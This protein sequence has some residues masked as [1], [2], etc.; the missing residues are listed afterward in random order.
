MGR[1]PAPAGVSARGTQRK[2]VMPAQP[3]AEPGGGIAETFADIA[4]PGGSAAA[5]VSRRKF[6]FAPFRAPAKFAQDIGCDFR[7]QQLLPAPAGLVRET[8]PDEMEDFVD[9][10][11]LKFAATDQKFRIKQ[12]AAARNIRRGEMGPE[13]DANFDADRP[14]GKM[15]Q[16]RDYLGGAARSG[17]GGVPAVLK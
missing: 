14:A 10:D 17:E 6:F 1:K 8:N 13:G 5:N 3:S 9:Q 12:D 7:C 11:A 16:H 2:F 15:R 4:A